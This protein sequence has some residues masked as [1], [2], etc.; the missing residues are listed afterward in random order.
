MSCI[1]CGSSDNLTSDHVPPKCLFP[2][3]RGPQITVPACRTCNQSY[4]K[5]DEYFAMATT[6]E[7]YIDHPVAFQVWEQNLRPM[8]L[9][10]QGLRRML[11]DSILDGNIT[12]LAG[13]HLPDRKG[14]RFKKSRIVRVVERIIRGLLWHHYG[15]KPSERSVFEVYRNPNFNDQIADLINSMTQLSSIG[16]DI[17]RYRHA[18]IDGDPDGSVWCLQF[19]NYSEWLTIVSGNTGASSSCKLGASAS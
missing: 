14:M 9:K 2:K 19:Y 5:D 1:Y 7:A 16:D 12:T 6:V 18:L 3:P 13:V 10:G 8:I 11:G 15:T 17:F 4:Q